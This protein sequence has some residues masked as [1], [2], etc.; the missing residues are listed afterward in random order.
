MRYRRIV[1]L[2]FEHIIVDNIVH[3][4]DLLRLQS[5]GEEIAVR[6]PGGV[7]GDVETIAVQ[8]TRIQELEKKQL[9]ERKIDNET[10]ADR[11]DKHKVSL[12]KSEAKLDERAAEKPSSC[13]R[14]QKDV[15]GE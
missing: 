11:L 7:L 6:S 15:T 5:F 13:E 2:V 9:E 8:V 4:E 3:G 12:K 1:G 14:L 10:L